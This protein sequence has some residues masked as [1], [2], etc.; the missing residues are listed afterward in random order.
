MLAD[1]LR[2]D[3]RP[4]PVSPPG[5]AEEPITGNARGRDD[6][7]LPPAHPTVASLLRDAGYATALAGKWH[8]GFPPHFG[9]LKSGYM[10][11]FGP[12][13]GGVD[14]FSHCDSGGTHDL[15]ENDAEVERSGYLT[16]LITDRAV[17][18]VVRQRGARAPF[19]LASTTPHR[20]GRGSPAPTKRNHAVSA[21][22]STTSTAARSRSTAR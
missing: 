2:V 5:A 11:H 17:D 22:R 4:L 6:L 19:L 10:E 16:D 12:L 14:Y 9:P 13:S 1:A 7:G 21:R 18:F 20:I 8:L 15:Y 3:D